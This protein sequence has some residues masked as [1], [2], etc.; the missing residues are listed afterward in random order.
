ML[1]KVFLVLAV[2]V[3]GVFG[4]LAPSWGYVPVCPAVNV[5]ICGNTYTIPSAVNGSLQTV[6]LPERYIIDSASFQCVGNFGAP[7]YKLM[8]GE[9]ENCQIVTC[10]PGVAT[11]CG[12]DIPVPTETQGDDIVS[13]P[14]DELVDRNHVG[15]SFTLAA[16]C[17]VHNGHTQYEV[18]DGGTMPCTIFMCRPVILNACG[19]EVA[20]DRS[21]PLGSVFN[22]VT[23]NNQ[24]VVVQCVSA[25]DGAPH[26]AVTDFLCTEGGLTSAPVSGDAGFGDVHV[27]WWF[28]FLE[29]DVD[30]HAAAWVPIAADA[31]PFRV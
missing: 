22:T 20:V 4:S 8:N 26:Y 9:V 14:Q 18:V 28:A 15:S 31:Q 19:T 29:K 21:A 10:A 11:I 24:P 13:L 17:R 12:I 23:S 25:I 1:C 5:Q 3:S 2:L 27:F 16:Q 7:F 30:R 6:H